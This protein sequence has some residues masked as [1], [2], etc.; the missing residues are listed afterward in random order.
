MPFASLVALLAALSTTVDPGSS[1]YGTLPTSRANAVSPRMQSGGPEPPAAEV[2]VGDRAPDFSYQSFD[3]RWRNLHD[4]RAQG[5]VLLVIAPSEPQLRAIER[6]RERLL[7]Y[8]IV[9][10]AVLDIPP[11]A[12]ASLVKRFE[13][14]YSVLADPRRVIAEQFNAVGGRTNAAMP[15]W[16]VIDRRGLVRA[17]DR[18][19]LP[20]GEYAP[21]AARALGL[22]PPG[23]ALPTGR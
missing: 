4:L 18:G 8:G 17:L 9:A 10:V 1:P 14:R 2:R 21:T 22:P 11:R 13:L 20:E 15:A 19:R 7:D 3:G 12:A 5:P 6:E 16:F 23:I